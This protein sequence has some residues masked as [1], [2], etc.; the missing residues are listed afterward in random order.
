MAKMATPGEYTAG[1]D[2]NGW[3]AA[4][5]AEAGMISGFE[6]LS[7][8]AGLKAGPQADGVRFAVHG[9]AGMPAMTDHSELHAT[10]QRRG[11]HA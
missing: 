11:R 6:A 9:G 7:L 8:E 3:A 4:A 5:G 10:K 2:R 1:N